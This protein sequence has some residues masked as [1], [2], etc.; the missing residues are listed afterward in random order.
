MHVDLI[1]KCRFYNLNAQRGARR[2]KVVC[3]FVCVWGS[4]CKYF[5]NLQERNEGVAV[6]KFLQS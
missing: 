5:L 1:T 4:V 6:V 2:Q 3:H